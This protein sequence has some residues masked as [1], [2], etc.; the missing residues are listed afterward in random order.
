[1]SKEQ[2]MPALG[3]AQLNLESSHK[4]LVS[5]RSAFTKAKERLEVAEADYVNSRVT[6]NKAVES[7]Q[8][9]CHLQPSGM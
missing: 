9:L 7:I 1:M 3:Q 2:T 5:A 6:L 8:Q 4:E